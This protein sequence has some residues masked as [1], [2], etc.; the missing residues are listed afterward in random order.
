MSY[1]GSPLVV[2]LDCAYDHFSRAGIVCSD[3]TP[4]R[5]FLELTAIENAGDDVFLIG[6]VHT[7]AATISTIL[8]A[9]GDG[10][11]SWR[12]PIT[13]YSGAGFELIQFTDSTHGW[14]GGQEGDYDRSTK[15]LLLAST[16]GGS[17]WERYAVNGD[18]DATG[19]VLEF[20]F[21]SPDHGLLI[22]DLLVSEGDPFELYETLNGGR[23]WNIRQI[24]S[25]KPKFTNRSVADDPI[26][27]EIKENVTESVYEVQRREQGEWVLKS[28][29]SVG[30]GSCLSMDR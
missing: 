11:R 24:A 18:E 19:T 6:N 10:G 15:P 27:W 30:V 8:L 16:D 9:S 21:D 13:R 20:F 23:S 12:E 5:L 29:F 22:V 25:Q 28:K 7:S 1:E 26:D 4:C 17:R 2:P 14:I 3:V